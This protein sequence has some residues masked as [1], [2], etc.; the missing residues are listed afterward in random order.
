MIITSKHNN[1]YQ[2]IQL[3]LHVHVQS[4]DQCTCFDKRQTH[5]KSYCTLIFTLLHIGLTDYK[6]PNIVD[7]YYHVVIQWS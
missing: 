3:Q 5:Q 6:T 1:N 2:M 7:T 4:Y